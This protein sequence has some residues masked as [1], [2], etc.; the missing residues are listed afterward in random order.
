MDEPHSSAD[1][2][3]ARGVVDVTAP[4]AVR[5]VVA[6]GGAGGVDVPTSSR[7]LRHRNEPGSRR[8]RLRWI[9]RQ[10]WTSETRSEQERV[11][12][13]GTPSQHP[14]ASG[15]AAGRS[16]VRRGADE[17]RGRA[18]P[19]RERS[20]TLVTASR[21]V[22]VGTCSGPIR[23]TG[24]HR[25]CGLATEFRS[26]V[27]ATGRED[28]QAGAVLG[29]LDRSVPSNVSP[30]RARR[31]GPSA[32]TT[33]SDVVDHVENTR[34]RRRVPVSTATTRRVRQH[35]CEASTTRTS[36]C[37]S[38]SRSRQVGAMPSGR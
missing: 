2:S 24:K 30:S 18:W 28:G 36:S 35:G 38:S 26:P 27:V 1:G 25:R 29:D 10:G 8:E 19:P 33:D 9:A 17:R 4:Q 11:A 12:R 6:M 16:G 15:I 7:Q 3:V 32:D 37:P 20:W 34:L 23:R 21:V 22:V 13:S 5:A 14:L 31:R